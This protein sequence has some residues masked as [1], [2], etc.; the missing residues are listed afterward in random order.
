VLALDEK[1]VV[2]VAVCLTRL[3]EQDQGRRV[4]CGVPKKRANFSARRPNA[5]CPNAP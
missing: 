1:L 2:L 5:S 3:R 4:Y